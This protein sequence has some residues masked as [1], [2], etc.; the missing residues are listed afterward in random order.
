[1]DRQIVF[2]AAIPLETDLLNAQRFTMTALG[3]IMQTVLGSSTLVQGLACAPTSPASMQVQVGA[4]SVYSLQNLDNTAYSS[5]AADTTHQIVKQGIVLDAQA[6]TITAPATAGTS[7]VYLVEA[8][9]LDSDTNPV[10]LPYYNSSNPAQAYSGPNNTGVAQ[11]TTR[12]GACSVQ[13]KAGVAAATGSQTVPA[14]DTGYTPLYTVTVAQGQT[15]I[16]AGNIAT[17]SGAPFV[18]ETL[19]SKISQ[20]TGDARYLKLSQVQSWEATDTGTAN[21]YAA[22]LSPVPGSITAGARVSLLISNTNTGA[23][24][25]NPN[26]LGA[27]A[28]KK[29]SGGALVNVASGDLP[30]GM[31]VDLEFDGTVWEKLNGAAI[32][33]A[34]NSLKTGASGLQVNEAITSYA[35]SQTLT[36]ANHLA[37]IV[38]TAA[39]T[40]T[41]PKASTAGMMAV[42][43]LAQGGAVTLTPNAAD[44]IQGGTVGANTVIPQG[45]SA[46]L[47]TDGGAPGNWWI[48]FQPGAGTVGAA[49]KNLKIAP[50]SNTA[51]ALTADETVLESPAFA[52]FMAR[53]VSLSLSTASTGANAL[54]TGAVAN[55]T[56]YSVWVIAT[57]AGTVAGL[58]SASATAPTLPT[59]YLYKARLGWVRTNASAN[60][61]RTIQYG[62]RAQWVVDGTL[63]TAPPVLASGAQGTWP[64]GPYAAVSVSNAV[65]STA[66]RIMITFYVGQNNGG[67]AAPGT[68][69]TANGGNGISGVIQ[70]NNNSSF[71]VQTSADMALESTNIAVVMQSTC[72]LACY[73]WEDNI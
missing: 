1:M 69:W 65:P 14:A 33:L 29:N 16:T 22:T 21:T 25:F 11:N 34:D 5:L 66:S 13:V 59:G 8:C 71:E 41:L 18:S 46:F 50:S 73:G 2:P 51:V 63:L 58:L 30:A 39:L 68:T 62:R 12:K 64:N 19:T 53:S 43:L 3:S 48:F 60:L 27:A 55:N 47:V 17:V 38:A 70:A 24:S 52:Y 10:V 4:G 40:L 36:A 54:D 23:S 42:A 56:W 6:F 28:I 31:L 45:S 15:T 26:G 20:A 7:Q 67:Y 37:N 72:I 9:Y 57:A 32:T 44:A 61:Y 49:F 35:T